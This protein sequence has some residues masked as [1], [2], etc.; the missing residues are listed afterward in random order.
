MITGV[1]SGNLS[2]VILYAW[3]H[4]KCAFGFQMEKSIAIN[5]VRHGSE[6]RHQLTDP[7][8]TTSRE[9]VPPTLEDAHKLAL[10]E[11]NLGLKPYRNKCVI[12]NRS[13]R[14]TDSARYF[15]LID[16]AILADRTAGRS[17]HAQGQRKPRLLGWRTSDYH[18]ETDEKAKADNWDQHHELLPIFEGDPYTKLEAVSPSGIAEEDAGSTEAFDQDYSAKDEPLGGT[19]GAP[20]SV[21]NSEE[22]PTS[23]HMSVEGERIALRFE[24]AIKGLLLS[25]EEASDLVGRVSRGLTILEVNVVEAGE[26]ALVTFDKWWDDQGQFN[27]EGSDSRTRELMKLA[28]EVGQERTHAGPTRSSYQPTNVEDAAA[29]NVNAIRHVAYGEG[30]RDG[31]DATLALI[32]ACEPASMEYLLQ[33]VES[34]MQAYRERYRRSAPRTDMRKDAPLLPE[35]TV[36]NA[37]FTTARLALAASPHREREVEKGLLRMSRG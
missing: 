15:A 26:G 5:R 33:A 27:A 25:K 22:K 8:N 12:D 13:G 1:R 28:F 32:Q 30:W 10:I 37:A 24:E 35:V 20:A 29:G 16:A 31:K 6:Q 9:T 2:Q 3:A 19:A 7:M 23:V 4:S 21:A 14:W 34:F 36:M 17:D 18:M 11:E